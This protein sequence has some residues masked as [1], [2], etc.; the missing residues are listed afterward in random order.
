[1]KYSQHKAWIV[2]EEPQRGLTVH[3]Y[4]QPYEGVILKLYMYSSTAMYYWNSGKA[5]AITQHY[6]GLSLWLG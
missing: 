5:N 6:A 1:M 4:L 2:K 3:C